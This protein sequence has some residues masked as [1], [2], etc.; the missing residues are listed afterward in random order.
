MPRPLRVEGRVLSSSIR[1]PREMWIHFVFTIQCSGKG[2]ICRGVS[3]SVAMRGCY[4]WVKSRFC[5]CWEFLM[6]SKHA[7]LEI[8]LWLN[9]FV[10]MWDCS[11]GGGGTHA[12]AHILLLPCS[13]SSHPV[14]LQGAFFFASF[15]VGQEKRIVMQLF[16]FALSSLFMLVAKSQPAF[17]PGIGD[18]M[19]Q[20]AA[21]MCVHFWIQW[22]RHFLQRHE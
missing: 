3:D 10:R 17:P 12:R 13:K 6:A 20:L 5:N 14:F 8:V 7:G 11:R 1:R 2:C 21:S 19:R 16:A 4:Y 15:Y 9:E 18:V 22:S